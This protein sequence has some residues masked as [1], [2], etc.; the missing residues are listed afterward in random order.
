MSNTITAFFK[1]R[2][3][4][5]EAVYQNDYGIVMKFDSIE[6]P[7]HF[8]C[9][10]S[11]MGEDE[12][13]PGIGADSQVVI[14]NSCLSK[15][16]TVTLHIPLHAG[17]NDSE[18]EYIVYFKVIGRARPVDDGTPAQMTAIEQAL[19]LLQNPIGNI[20][21]IVNE[22][23]SFTGDT[24]AEMQAALDADQAAF[25]DDMGDRA[26]AFEAEIRGDI[27]DVESD[28]DNL[29]AQFQTAVSAVTTDT[30]V[31]NVR[32]GDDGITYTT[33]G[34]AV[35]TQ[36]ANSKG[37]LGRYL[38]AIND[39]NAVKGAIN[40]G[41]ADANGVLV[42]IASSS[43]RA[44]IGP[45][46]LD[47]SVE[48]EC[49]SKIK[50]KLY[51][52]IKGSSELRYFDCY[53]TWQT[54]K[55]IEGVNPEFK[56]MYVYYFMVAYADDANIADAKAFK[57]LLTLRSVPHKN[58]LGLCATGT[59]SG[60]RPVQ[61]NTAQDRILFYRE[62]PNLSSIA[63]DVAYSLTLNGVESNFVGAKP[64]KLKG[65]CS[66]MVQLTNNMQNATSFETLYEQL[67][68]S[69][70]LTTEYE[71]SDYK[72]AA[73]TYGV[74][75]GVNLV[76]GEP[77]ISASNSRIIV[78]A[79]HLMHDAE[80]SCD[81]GYMYKIYYYYTNN[82]QSQTKMID[83]FNAWKSDQ[84]IIGV[85]PNYKNYVKYYV[86]LSKSDSS[87][88][89]SPDD[90][91]AHFHIKNVDGQNPYHIIECEGVN[92]NW[93]PVGT[94]DGS[95]FGRV[96]FETDV[97]AKA[98]FGIANSGCVYSLHWNGTEIVGNAQFVQSVD[99]GHIRCMARTSSLDRIM[100]KF[101]TFKELYDYLHIINEPYDYK[102]VEGSNLFDTL[103]FYPAAKIRGDA[104]L[105]NIFQDGI[106]LDT[107]GIKFSHTPM[108]MIHDGFA[109]IAF[110][111]N[112]AEAETDQYTSIH[113][114]V[115][116][117]SN[118]TTTY[119]K[120]AG[121]GTYGGVTF[122][123]ACTNPY[124]YLDTA[125]E[126]IELV[127]SAH[128]GGAV[129]LCHCSYDL[130]NGTFS[131]GMC[132]I[133]ASSED[134]DFNTANFATYIGRP[135]GVKDLGYEIIMSKPA[136]INGELYSA[137]SSGAFSNSISV[138]MKSSDY[139]KWELF[140][141]LPAKCGS[142][143]EIAILYKNGYLYGASRHMYSDATLCIWKMQVSNKR[144]IDSV[145]IPDTAT[146]P[147]FYEAPNGYIFLLH[148]LSGRRALQVVFVNQNT[149]AQSTNWI[150]AAEVSG[151]AYNSVDD[152]GVNTYIAIQNSYGYSSPRIRFG[153]VPME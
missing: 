153:L 106:V 59:I 144:I 42:S 103:G 52:F 85:H 146:R 82:N 105:Q 119:V 99:K 26:D 118:Y 91:K 128:I 150:E 69:E 133:T 16:G 65:N 109:Y 138:I 94:G 114:A 81:S 45:F 145:Q 135:N 127:F 37:A 78:G 20:E 141:V 13:I 67:G 36:F 126:T 30:E 63:M 79:F 121:L 122:D 2:V 32:V 61:V 8:D 25:Q 139:V 107:D 54:T 97:N 21:Q 113:L 3:G 9:Y 64:S 47:T 27:A 95:A 43:S 17:T 132:K 87:A 12:A 35:R 22:A 90:I 23:L 147:T 4:V 136:M 53:S 70:H 83:M 92:A 120:L 6:L 44:V 74:F 75:N 71:S 68:Y 129:C 124:G 34:E 51:R 140:T 100:P 131:N 57:E 134:Y 29:N 72:D 96:F 62:I 112:P 40:N 115:I 151:L 84:H 88:I 55:H 143:C 49:D 10:F 14:P 66:I 142:D 93:E 102:Q 18:V 48:I 11:V 137:V 28:F 116:N 77:V 76:N 125:N 56:D 24:F 89:V 15:S 7:A 73:V 104:L 101:A 123:G 41:T 149:L 60:G 108:L 110:Q 46:Q 86:L 152:D 39:A 58:P 19:A 117:L 38:S 5:A 148:G 130:S 98:Y 50:Y 111:A 1:G 31:T 33:A 80:I